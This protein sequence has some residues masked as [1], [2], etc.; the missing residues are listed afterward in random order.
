VNPLLSPKQLAAKLG[1]T[2]KTILEWYH[3]GI[4]PAEVALGKIYRFDEPKIRAVLAKLAAER[5]SN[6]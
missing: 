6:R 5:I 2:N 3:A 4:I 1:T